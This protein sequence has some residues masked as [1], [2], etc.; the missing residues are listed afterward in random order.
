MNLRTLI[1]ALVLTLPAGSAFADRYGTAGC[2]LG[3]IAFGDKKGINQTWAATTNGTF[4]TQT[5][6]ITSGTSNCVDSED[7]SSVDQEAFM[8]V[9]YGAIAKE[10]AEGKGEHLMAMGVLLGC[11]ASAHPQ[12]FATIQQNHDQIFT[13]TR[14]H[15]QALHGLKTAA[16]SNPALAGS[17]ARL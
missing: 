16:R 6:G 8:K 14:N 13:P 15:L 4:G 7:V 2:G 3:S 17:C 1:I 9:N 12:L 11:E 10:G 5:F